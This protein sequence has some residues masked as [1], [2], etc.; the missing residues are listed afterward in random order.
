MKPWERSWGWQGWYKEHRF[1]E[2]GLGK[3]KGK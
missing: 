3:G 1:A 2:A